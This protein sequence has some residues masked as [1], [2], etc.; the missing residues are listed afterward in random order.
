MLRNLHDVLEFG[1][2]LGEGRQMSEVCYLHC[3]RDCILF[4][5]KRHKKE[6]YMLYNNICLVRT[7]LDE[8]KFGVM[9]ASI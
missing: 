9:E 8:G 6:K 7:W 4:M 5:L 2:E 3:E 1:V